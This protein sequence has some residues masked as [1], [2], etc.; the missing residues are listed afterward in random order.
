MHSNENSLRAKNIQ[1]K[2][3]RSI[4]G[5]NHFYY[6]NTFQLHFVH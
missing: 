3:A 1:N 5:L 4:P 6:L 2:M